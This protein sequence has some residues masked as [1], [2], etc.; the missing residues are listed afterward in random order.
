M[1][2]DG[3]MHRPFDDKELAALPTWLQLIVQVIFKFGVPSAIAIYLVWIGASNLPTLR[4]E[5]AAQHHELQQ[6]QQ[7]LTVIQAQTKEIQ[8]T[9]NWLCYHAAKTEIEKR[10]CFQP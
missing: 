2:P 8:Q 3:T 10:A 5:L 7:T 4:L 9:L 1:C 6:V